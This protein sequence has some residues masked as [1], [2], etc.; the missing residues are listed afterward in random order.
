MNLSDQAKVA[1]CL[2]NGWDRIL[3]DKFESKTEVFFRVKGPDRQ[4]LETLFKVDS[5]LIG[6]K[7]KFGQTEDW[8]V[9]TIL[10]ED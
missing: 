9:I 2:I 1:I 4:A 5:L 6:V 8:T 3:I 10:K 7:A